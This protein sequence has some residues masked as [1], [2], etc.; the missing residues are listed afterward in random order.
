MPIRILRAE[1]YPILIGE[2]IFDEI[3]VHLREP[4]RKDSK[5]ILMVDENTRNLCLPLLLE[6]LEQFRECTV[7][8]IPSGEDRK[9]IQT[10]VE[11]WQNLIDLKADKDSVLVNIGGGVL[12]DIAGFIA[13]TYKRGIRY[14]NFPTTLVGQIDAA[15]GGKVGVNLSDLKNQIGVFANPDAVCIYTP[16]LKTLSARDKLSGFAEVVKYAL[17][18]DQHFWKL[19][20]NV[21]FVQIKFWDDIIY[22]SVEIK[23]RIVKNDPLD[24]RLR[25]RLNFGHTLGHAFETIALQRKDKSM[26]HGSGVAMGIICE[27]FLSCKMKGLSWEILE[28][29]ASYILQNFPYYTL[30]DDDVDKILEILVHDKKNSGDQINFTLIPSLGHA[31]IDQYCEPEDILSCLQFYRELD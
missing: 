16:F 2:D 7:I 18:M 1:T 30:E 28:E 10:C 8:E 14:I 3:Q 23:N 19:L 26:T 22:R 31:L 4:E 13:A 21:N 24:K 9:N 20:R 11:I 27:T 15:F 25:K 6:K 29:I 5:F 12:T 17:I